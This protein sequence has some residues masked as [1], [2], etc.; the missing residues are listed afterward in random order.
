[1]DRSQG[2]QVT[3]DNTGKIVLA[4]GDHN[5]T[6]EVT[7]IHEGPTTTHYKLGGVLA[8]VAILA[9]LGIVVA[10][11]VKVASWLKSEI[12]P[13]TV[14]SRSITVDTLCRDYLQASTEERD[15]AV[16]AIGL[17]KGVPNAG[18]PLLRLSVD[19]SCGGVPDEPV[20]SMIVK[21]TQ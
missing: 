1:G 18:S 9:V 2:L 6:N 5:E 20:G 13:E 12:G 17:A 3:G 21:P 8:V 16:K 19:A 14:T 7:T 10:G 15:H 11:A 4:G